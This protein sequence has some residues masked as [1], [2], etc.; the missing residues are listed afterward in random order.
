M[1]SFVPLAVPAPAASRHQP[2]LVMVP[3]ALTDHFCGAV[4]LHS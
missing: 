1:I 2:W 4:P 3:S